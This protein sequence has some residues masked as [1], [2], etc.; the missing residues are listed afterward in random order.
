MRLKKPNMLERLS[1]FVEMKIRQKIGPV[2]E[3]H[4]GCGTADEWVDYAKRK[5]AMGGFLYHLAETIDWLESFFY[6][7][8]RTLYYDP[9]FWIKN[10]FIHPRWY[11]RAKTLEVGQWYDLDTSMLHINMQMVVD[12]IEGEKDGYPWELAEMDKFINNQPSQIE[13]D[14]KDGIPQR[15]YEDMKEVWEIYEWWQNYPKRQ[16]E[17]DAI[18]GEIPERKQESDCS[19]EMFSKENMDISRPYHDRIHKLEEKLEQEEEEMLIRLM[20]VRKS[21]WT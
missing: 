21:L 1:D 10:M 17:I 6:R 18:Y 3:K 14:F 2:S 12:F 7:W 9:R 15:Q 5:K 4:E 8:S 20:K 16:K 13:V 11:I 19:L